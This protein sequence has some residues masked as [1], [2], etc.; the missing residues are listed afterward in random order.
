MDAMPSLTSPDE[1]HIISCTSVIQQA[2][3][4][5]FLK[6]FIHLNFERVDS[7]NVKLIYRTFDPAG[8]EKIRLRQKPSSV[9]LDYRL[10]R[11]SKSD[12]GYEWTNMH[13]GGLLVVR[14]ANGTKVI[15]LK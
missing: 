8:I 6:K 9:L 11:E 4:E 3:Y 10:L 12:E 7:S 5:G 15:V 1:D 2:D 14:R 13:E